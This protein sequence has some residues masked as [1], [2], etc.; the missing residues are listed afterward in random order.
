MRRSAKNARVRLEV[1]GNRTSFLNRNPT[2][3]EDGHRRRVRAWLA[4]LPVFSRCRNH[5]TYLRFDIGFDAVPTRRFPSRTRK[6][7]AKRATTSNQSRARC[8]MATMSSIQS[9]SVGQ[10]VPAGGA[11]ADARSPV[12]NGRRAVPVGGLVGSSHQL[13]CRD[14][15]LS[16]KANVQRHENAKLHLHA[17]SRLRERHRVR[18]LQKGATVSGTLV[19]MECDSRATARRRVAGTCTRTNLRPR[20]PSRVFQEYEQEYRKSITRCVSLLLYSWTLDRPAVTID[21]RATVTSRV[22]RM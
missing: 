13:R 15:R 16:I 2:L 8:K 19:E 4:E 5:R 22:M 3:S 14:K 20:G 18:S 9:A 21:R 17:T 11:V 1:H 6:A 10:A 7:Q 12:G